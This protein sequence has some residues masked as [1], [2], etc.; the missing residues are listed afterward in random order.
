VIEHFSKKR[1]KD[2]EN[3]VSE[4]LR[5]PALVESLYQHPLIYSLF[6]KPYTPGATNLPSYIPKR[7]FALALMD[8]ACP[9]DEQD[10]SGAAGSTGAGLAG[11]V[12]AGV[13]DIANKLPK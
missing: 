12:G 13:Q 5:D 1:A 8:I 11:S 3:G 4:M 2:L 7:N 10:K 6:P 9:S